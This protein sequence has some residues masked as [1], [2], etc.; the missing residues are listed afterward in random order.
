MRRL[1]AWFR[2]DIPD[3]TTLKIIHLFSEFGLNSVCQ[4]ARCP[5]ITEC[6]KNKEVTFMILGA[7]CTR[8]CR[9]C[10][11]DKSEGAVRPIDKDE[12]YRIAEVVKILGL[13]YVVITSVSRDDLPDG[14]AGQFV[15]TLELIHGLNKDIKIEL[16]IPDFQGKISSV[17]CILAAGPDVLAH[18]I[19]TVRRLY[20]ELRPKA[21]Y[22]LSLNILSKI[23]EINP[24][25]NTKSS[26]ILGLGESREEVIGTMEDLKKHCCD[27][28]TL[29]QYLA[30][31]VNHYP[32]KEFISIEQFQEYQDTGI[33]MGFKV[34]FSGPKVRSSYQAQELQKELSL[35]TI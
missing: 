16:L 14:G 3:E 6:F 1:P 17:E 34:V 30:P 10:A 13:S 7:S 33:R 25:I 18:N 26:I 22:Q 31:S 27:I 29:G 12:P 24:R 32:V 23:K 21:D 15:K 8:N 20:A 28:L 4:E 5:N 19:E 2:Q 11:V 35:C 9:F